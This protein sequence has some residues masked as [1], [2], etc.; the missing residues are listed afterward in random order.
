MKGGRKLCNVSSMV[1]KEKLKIKYPIEKF[2]IMNLSVKRSWYFFSVKGNQDNL[3][4]SFV[5]ICAMIFVQ[6]LYNEFR[7]R[8]RKMFS[9]E[10]VCIHREKKKK[11]KK[12]MDQTREDKLY[13]PPWLPFR[14]LKIVQVRSP[15]YGQAD[16]CKPLNCT[17]TCHSSNKK[18]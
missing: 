3:P 6:V 11:R 9:K 5:M 18:S 1:K 15:R 7:W 14:R 17:S 12:G 10:F 4:V 8:G 16:F 13:V 2:K